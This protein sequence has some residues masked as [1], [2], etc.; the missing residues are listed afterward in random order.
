MELD[1]DF[2]L[3]GEDGEEREEWVDHSNASSLEKYANALEQVLTSWNLDGG[4][5]AGEVSPEDAAGDNDGW[6]RTICVLGED[7]AVASLFH[8]RSTQSGSISSLPTELEHFT[9]T[10]FAVVNLSG[11]SFVDFPLQYAHA[12]RLWFGV[13]DYVVVQETNLPRR[14]FWDLSALPGW[15][16]SNS[17]VKSSMSSIQLSAVH[18]AL[19]TCNCSIPVLVQSPQRADACKPGDIKMLEADSYSGIAM[20]GGKDGGVTMYFESG[21]FKS[22]QVLPP[23]AQNLSGLINLFSSELWPD[24]KQMP[25]EDTASSLDAKSK[26]AMRNKLLNGDVFVSVRFSWTKTLAKSKA[27]RIHADA[28]GW[29]EWVNDDVS[30]RFKHALK[31]SR[32]ANRADAIRCFSGPPLWGPLADPL[33]ALKLYTVWPRFRQG[34]FVQNAVFTNL[35][36]DSSPLWIVVPDWREEDEGCTPLAN[37]LHCLNRLL[38]DTQAYPTDLMLSSF[39]IDGFAE[40]NLLPEILRVDESKNVSPRLS[41]E[42]LQELLHRTVASIFM[43]TQTHSPRTLIPSDGTSQHVD[44]FERILSE[45]IGETQRQDYAKVR[46]QAHL[47]LKRTVHKSIPAE[48]YT[49]AAEVEFCGAPPGSLLSMVS[50]RALPMLGTDIRAVARLWNEVAFEVRWHWENAVPIALNFAERVLEKPA[51][52][53]FRLVH[54]PRNLHCLLQQKMQLLNNCIFLVL[55][56]KYGTVFAPLDHSEDE[57]FDAKSQED[58]RS[59]DDEAGIAAFTLQDGS[60]GRMPLVFENCFMTSEDVSGLESM[61]ASAPAV[62]KQREAELSFSNAR[63]FKA[64][65]PS[66]TYSDFQLWEQR[67][68]RIR[69]DAFQEEDWRLADAQPIVEQETLAGFSVDAEAEKI[70]HYIETI[71]PCDLFNQLCGVGIASSVYIM[72]NALGEVGGELTTMNQHMENLNRAVRQAFSDRECLSPE[73]HGPLKS[74]RITGEST[75]EQ[76]ILIERIMG[77]EG[78]LSRVVS[79]SNHFSTSVVDGSIS[80]PSGTGAIGDIVPLQFLIRASS[81]EHQLRDEVKRHFL[82]HGKWESPEV[83]EFLLRCITTRSAVTLPNAATHSYRC[84][85][86][87]L[88]A[89]LAT[90]KIRIATVYTETSF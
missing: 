73:K 84:G 1:L 14:K 56:R 29:S 67:F 28:V 15:W 68:M 34:T 9:P 3:Q 55:A 63:A 21:L 33:V 81:E 13:E 85:A 24:R 11:D 90:D 86:N 44:Q 42:A 25:A 6:C 8:G 19:S 39:A 59:N 80:A 10:S 53:S 12:A 2:I 62:K 45:N 40:Q 38:L 70:L 64:A 47:R 78:M 18:M 50:L 72:R 4:K 41:K 48:L 20:P 37:G 79:L 23:S 35:S 31:D 32:L 54:L 87:R 61:L 77:F 36:P 26:G 27:Q 49:N 51:N 82:V 74:S 89:A 22:T 57:F 69:N 83:Q 17:A 88:Y 46:A 58:N 30:W 76:S 43:F 75:A 65:N 16:S 66:S 7:Y 52:D 5:G 71:E 60:V